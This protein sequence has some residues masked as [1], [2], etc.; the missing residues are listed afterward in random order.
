[1]K[2]QSFT[3]KKTVIAGATALTLLSAPLLMARPSIIATTGASFISTAL[4]AA[5][6]GS[7]GE[8]H[9]GA[10]AGGSKQGGQA[11]GTK[12]SGGKK[13]M[14][15]VLEEGEDDSDRPAWAGGDPT[16]NPHSG[17][18]E[19]KPAGAGT[20]KG[21]DYGDLIVLL[22]NPL[23]GEPILED[24]EFLVC[25]D[26]A[27]TST[28]PTVDGEVPAGVTPVEVD[29][30]R[31]AVARSPSKVS[32][33]SLTD[34]LS[35]LTADGAVISQDASGRIVVTVDGLS[36]TIDSPLENLALYIDL[37]TGLASTSVTSLTETALGSSLATLQTAASLLAAV[38]D[39]TGDISIDYVV[40]ENVI[41]GVVNSGDYYN[42]TTFSYDRLYPEDYSY[43]YTIDG[44]TTVL[45]AVLNINTYLTEINGALP[46]DG[47]AILFAAA[48]DDA[49]EVIELLHTQIYSEI[50]PGTVTTP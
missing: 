44:G 33:K 20:K 9:K 47:G 22:R 23:T 21:D 13:G 15:K 16:A 18:G 25:L 43:F 7:G 48:A 1:M 27:C 10:G 11:D 35:K 24:G 30:G 12:G 49:V 39:K 8:G 34:A 40:Y 28:I 3:M 42:F 5:G 4:A 6:E 38:G 31:S 36:S 50:L 41:A 26:A 46:S 37:M 32:D 45:S 2:T 17:G 14:D 19:G 29:F